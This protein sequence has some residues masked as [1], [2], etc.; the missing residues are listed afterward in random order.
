MNMSMDSIKNIILNDNQKK[1]KSFHKKRQKKNFKV[2]SFVKYSVI[3][4]L[5]FL[6][7]GIG[8]SFSF[9]SMNSL[10]DSEHK[11][12]SMTS[13]SKRS[14]TRIAMEREI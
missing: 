13:M 4:V 6:S 1:F 2:K 3:I 7:I 14:N 11:L 8:F 5:L 9:P 12:L 10:T